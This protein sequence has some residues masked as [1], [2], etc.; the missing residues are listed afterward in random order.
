[1]E[2]FFD[3]VQQVQKPGL[4]HRCGGC[5]TFCTAVNFGAL[6]LDQDG[7]PR[8]G[9]ME[10]CIECGL[11]YCICPE[12]EE[13]EEE[14]RRKVAWSAPNGRIIETSVVR[15]ADTAVRERGTDG[16]VVTALLLHL[17]DNGRIDGA[18]V[19]KP[20]GPFMRRPSLAV[21]R[22]E[23]EDAAGFYFDTSHGMKHLSDRYVTY[24]SIEEFAPMMKKGLRRV[25]LVGT[26]CQIKAYRRMEVL[27]IVP[28]DSIQYCL[29]LFCSGNFTFDP[30]SR[31]K[32]ADTH[33]FAWDNVK[34][35]NIKDSLLIHLDNGEIRS[36]AL[37]DLEFMK[38]VACRY[39]PD[40]SAEFADISFGGIG[41]PE[42]WTTVI[43]RTPL[44]RAVLADA[45]GNA[46]EELDQR[47]NPGYASGALAEM[48]EAAD[49]KKK[50]ARDNRKELGKK[51]VNIKG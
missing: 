37:E 6:E 14:T 15:S 7:K 10:K 43:T 38:R 26:P 11:C 45:R 25:A 41:A 47:Q 32:L 29:G 46:V 13:F 8:Y 22:E 42:G 33:G 21:T 31:K 9:D 34:K 30:E 23:I 17:F 27:G 2:T 36:I 50:A 19:T 44:G 3:L 28:S 51:P 5:V 48:R 49:K 20:A 18:I 24:S 4:C 12:I 39:C 1:M 35:I 16:G 40:Y